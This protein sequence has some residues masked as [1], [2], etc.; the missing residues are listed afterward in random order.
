MITCARISTPEGGSLTTDV[1][2]RV[3]QT[4]Q[5]RM[6]KPRRPMYHWEQEDTSL[7]K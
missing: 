7:S 4:E 3:E 6:E 1:N 2:T 5:C